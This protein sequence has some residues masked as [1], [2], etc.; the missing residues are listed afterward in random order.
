MIYRTKTLNLTA[1]GFFSFERAMLAVDADDGITYR[2]S[3]DGGKTFQVIN[4]H[5]EFR[6]ISRGSK[7]VM[8]IRF[9]DTQTVDIYVL[10]ITG[11]FPLNIGTTLFF[12]DGKNTFSTV[13]G[14]DGR[15]SIS[16]PPGKYTVF[17]NVSGERVVLS[18]NFDPKQHSY[19]PPDDL[20]KENVIESFMSNIDWADLSV[21]DTF[22]D[23]SKMSSQST[24][25]IDL[26]HNLTDGT[27]IVRYW[28]LV[29][30]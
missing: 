16:L 27:K 21:Y 25:K 23:R 28:A 17:H 4:P 14:S 19:R 7:I 15:Y 12:T 26:A 1:F 11:V 22:V 2:V 30:A 18:E 8:E 5:I 10:N 20:D 24:A 6:P 13:V 9:N 3:F 29:L